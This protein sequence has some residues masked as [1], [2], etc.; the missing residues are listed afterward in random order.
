MQD[1]KMEVDKG[2]I[3]VENKGMKSKIS[4]PKHKLVRSNFHSG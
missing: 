1:N 3:E 4:L 2:H